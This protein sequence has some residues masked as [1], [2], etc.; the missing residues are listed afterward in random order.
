MAGQVYGAVSINQFFYTPSDT[1]VTL[2]TNTNILSAPYKLSIGTAA[3]DANG[4]L[5]IYGASGAVRSILRSGDASAVTTRYYN[6]RAGYSVGV[7]VTDSNRFQLYDL[8]NTT[9]RMTV[10]SAGQF[11]IGNANPL[12]RFTVATQLS[13]SPRY[14]IDDSL[15]NYLT[16]KRYSYSGTGTNYYGFQEYMN[17][18]GLYFDAAASVAGIGSHDFGATQ[19]LKIFYD[20]SVWITGQKILGDTSLVSEGE[21]EDSLDAYTLTSAFNLVT[22]DTVKWDS[23]YLID[24]MRVTEGELEDSLDGYFT[25]AATRLEIED[26]LD[27]Y[28][29]TSGLMVIDSTVAG[30]GLTETGNTINANGANGITVAADTIKVDTTTIATK[31]F[32]RDSG[33]VSFITSAEDLEVI[34]NATF[35]GQVY[36]QNGSFFFDTSADFYSHPPDTFM[37]LKQYRGYGGGTD[38]VI[39]CHPSV[40]DFPGGFGF[41]AGDSVDPTTNTDSAYRAVYWMI[42]TP[43]DGDSAENP[44][45][46]WSQRSS[47]VAGDNRTIKVN[48]ITNQFGWSR[49]YYR[50]QYNNP[51]L[52]REPL[53]EP[54]SIQANVDHLSDATLGILR[55]GRMAVLYRQSI[56]A[57]GD[58]LATITS[59][60]G[61]IWNNAVDTATCMSVS[62]EQAISPTF[63]L[64]QGEQNYRVWYAQNAVDGDS[65]QIKT[66]WVPR[67]DSTWF[68]DADS[69]VVCSFSNYPLDTA[70][71]K[72]WHLSVKKYTNQYHMLVMFARDSTGGTCEYCDLYKAVSND[73]VNWTFLNRPW[74]QNS[75]RASVDS[76]RINRADEVWVE[77]GYRGHFAVFYGCDQSAGT[78]HIA[79]RKVYVGSY[80]DV[81]GKVAGLDHTPEDSIMLLLPT[82]VKAGD[83]TRLFVDTSYDAGGDDCYDTFSVF[84]DVNQAMYVDTF[85]ACLATTGSLDSI[86]FWGKDFSGGLNLNDSLYTKYTTAFTTTTPTVLTI[87]LQDIIKS[88]KHVRSGDRITAIFYTKHADAN[89]KLTC[90]WAKLRGYPR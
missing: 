75:N 24:T 40:V 59:A 39:Q 83:T 72:I 89:D 2:R 37:F 27:E 30:T 71:W 58:Q 61:L 34:G 82:Q 28:T 13:T 55:D 10:D 44:T 47:G 1:V 87:A 77:D 48:D 4:K 67:L 69:G 66:M 22:D 9:V 49:P 65:T 5:Y 32:V 46:F 41:N 64:G 88:G 52:I 63:A 73:G 7:S 20:G 26:S 3:T 60:N 16:M 54:D 56:V 12:G 31:Q 11:C 25:A 80:I 42:T 38:S 18:S 35:Y 19:E 62:G 50:D 78:D 8:L 14:S 57:G 6:S 85:K 43:I 70:G 53:I 76:G 51:I 36:Q 81:P 86:E 21:L 68:A 33:A 84:F 29:P 45:L 90:Y 15:T 79:A 23:L 74:I 17:D